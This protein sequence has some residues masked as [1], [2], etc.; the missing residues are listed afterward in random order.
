MPYITTNHRFIIDD[1]HPTDVFDE[2]ENFFSLYTVAI[3][4]LQ[5]VSV[6][7][8]VPP[9]FDVTANKTLAEGYRQFIKSLKYTIPDINVLPIKTQ[10]AHTE[11]DSEANDDNTVVLLIQRLDGYDIDAEEKPSLYQSVLGKLMP[12]FGGDKTDTG[13]YP[14]REQIAIPEPA[15]PTPPRQ[16]PQ[17]QVQ[18]QTQIPPQLPP[19]PQQPY[20]PPV[21]SVA[22]VP[23]PQPTLQQAPLQATQ[24]PQPIQSIQPTGTPST[25]QSV[26]P[27]IVQPVSRNIERLPNISKS[28]APYQAILTQAILNEAKKQA[29]LLNQPITQITLKSGD[30]LTTAMIEQLFN[31]FNHAHE[32]N[33]PHDAIDLVS[34]GYEILK[35][36]LAKLGIQLADDAGFGLKTNAKATPADIARLQSGGVFSNEIN[37]KVKLTTAQTPAS[38][39]ANHAPSANHQAVSAFTQPQLNQNAQQITL[40]LK[41]SDQ[42]GER[43]Q[44]VSH[45]PIRFVSQ[46]RSS[47][48][49]SSQ[50]NLPSNQIIRLFVHLE[51]SATASG[52]FF[53]IVELDGNV[54]LDRIDPSIQ[55]QRQGQTLANATAL[56]PNDVLTIR[57]NPTNPNVGQYP[58]PKGQTIQATVQL[59]VPN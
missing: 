56:M 29:T 32:T 24:P 13:L 21:A 41:I 50:D 40:M 57:E 53:D 14:K 12:R 1:K 8:S 17:A 19:Q 25:P 5:Q 30:S 10:T 39:S 42:L 47:Q 26:V 9:N 49:A 38:T 37:L 35:P 2:M 45:F 27:P 16:A 7:L 28:A 18:P 48:N 44:K 36:Q 4:D 23:T 59:L 34:Y 51:N 11:E 58:N 54:W 31:S 20:V 46:N 43:Q 6:Q 15:L 22:N 52:G 55:V 3:D 33:S